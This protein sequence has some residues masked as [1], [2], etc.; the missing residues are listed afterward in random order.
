VAGVETPVLIEGAP[1][2]GIAKVAE[3]IHRLSAKPPADLVRTSSVSLSR[4]GLGDLL[5]RAST[6]TVF[7]DEVV[8][9]PGETQFALLEHLESGG[10]PRIIAGTSGDLPF[11]LDQGM[12]NADLYYHLQALKITV[13]AL[14]ERSEDIPA[15]FCHYVADIAAKANLDEPDIPAGFLADLMARDW[16]GNTRALMN[17]ATRF[18]LGLDSTPDAAPL[19]LVEKLN[20]VERALLIDALTRL[21]GNAS[22]AAADLKLPRKTFYDK[23]ARHGIKPENYR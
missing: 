13:P 4:D 23:L 11:A 14:A 22:A 8:R 6:G 2:T 3:V 9:L 12:F 16:P 10:S 1:G 21:G 20:Q 7:L 15:I 17:E 5:G 18:V 19:G